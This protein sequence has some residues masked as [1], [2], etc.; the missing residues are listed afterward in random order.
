MEYGK[1]PVG[2]AVMLHLWLGL[3]LVGYIQEATSQ[4]VL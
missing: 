4:K 1:T 2:G 3:C